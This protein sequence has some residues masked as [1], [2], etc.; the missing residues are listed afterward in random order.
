MGAGIA[1]EFLRKYWLY[2]VVAL[3]VAA[4]HA[5][6]YYAGGVG[7]RADLEKERV[8]HRA[9]VAALM[10]E[11]KSDKEASNALIKGK[12]EELDAHAG[13]IN[14][15]W[16]EYLARLCPRG[17]DASGV[18]VGPERRPVAEP[19]RIAATVCGDAAG[20]DRLSDA[21]QEHRREV[22]RVIQAERDERDRIL[23][24]ERRGAGALL[25]TC[26]RQAD[27]LVNL[28][29]VWAGERVINAPPG[30]PSPGRI[31]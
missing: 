20:N 6:V 31:D 16:I 27:A 21:V 3:A 10:A 1:L 18:C 26:E 17:I 19:V 29:D 7:P 15:D 23:A 24:E 8:E 2:I 4:W 9:Q 14:A 28:Q 30:P 12:D 11:Q 22:G 25:K 13:K 5:A